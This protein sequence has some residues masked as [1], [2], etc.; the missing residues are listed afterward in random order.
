M[1]FRKVVGVLGQCQCKKVHSHS[2]QWMI[3]SET[4]M[5]DFSWTIMVPTWEI[6]S[7]EN[8]GPDDVFNFLMDLFK[9][10]P[11]MNWGRKTWLSSSREIPRS[12]TPSDPGTGVEFRSI[13][14]S[15]N[16]VFLPARPE[17]LPSPNHWGRLSAIPIPNRNAKKAGIIAPDLATQLL[18]STK[19]E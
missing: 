7:R 8:Y 18:S 16:W 9:T 17:P 6:F 10:S 13:T 12:T 4:Q 1:R 5:H 15:F 14:I 19:T 3:H 11:R 2:L